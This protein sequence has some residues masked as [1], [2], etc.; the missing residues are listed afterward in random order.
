MSE[1]VVTAP[2]RAES[3]GHGGWSDSSARS[4]LQL[5]VESVTEMVGFEVAVVSVVVGGDLVTV[6]YAGPEEFREQIM[7]T[8][9]VS[10]LD[11]VFEQAESW[12]RFVFLA[13]EDIVGEFE[14]TWVETVTELGEGPDAWHPR[15]VLLGVLT[16]DRGELCGILSV[17][18]PTSKQRPDAPQRRLL[19][20]YAHQTERAVITAF[21]RE[22]LVQ[23]VAH[24]E[25]ARRLIRTASMPGHASLE[26]VL[27]H[28]HHPLVEGFDASGSWIHVLGSD[29]VRPGRARARDG[30]VVPLTDAVVDLARR[31]A[32]VLWAEQQVLVVADDVDSD[33]PVEFSDPLLLD[34]ARFQLRTLGLTST[35]AV[36]LGVG[37]ECLGF[38]ALTRRAQDPPWSAVET[39]S[40]LEIG[41]DL[42][43]ALMTARALERERDLVAE[44][45]RLDDYRTHLIETLSH[46]MRTPLTVISGNL[47]MLEEVELDE[48]ATHFRD[49]MSRGTARMQRVVD[50]LLL[51]AAV[52][53]PQH[54]LVRMPVD[55]R[56]VVRDVFGLIESTATAKGLT[57][58]ATL[59]DPDLVVS[60]HAGEIDRLLSNLVS[61]AVKYTPA[62][63]TVVLSAIRA[64]GSVILEVADTGLGISEEDQVGLFT[65]FYR[66]TNPDALREPGTGLGLSIVA[67]IAQRHG[68][69]VE[70]NSCLGKGTT[71][72]VTL[73]VA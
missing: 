51:L 57:L 48:G 62:G 16:D 31:L 64:S 66:T 68:G 46:E 67:H 18:K 6:A 35:L 24:A 1:E 47:E 73:P 61:N 34:D 29:S 2:A 53:H 11:P 40:A 17:D 12:G 26:A 45:Q 39:A 27:D 70:V 3:A 22:R 65:S 28:T 43:A 14:G 49:A 52:S 8:D 50:D 42:G 30:Q 56:E 36:P 19:E 13:A 33:L 58:Q 5:V 23:Q 38:L 71:F 69:S 55:L 20:R 37:Q 7:I 44:L 59:R 4:V 10:V 72:T 63:G 54:P 15:D 9:P 21:E 60:G 25:A 32:P 41:H